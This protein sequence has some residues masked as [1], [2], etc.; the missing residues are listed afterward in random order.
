[1]VIGNELDDETESNER[2]DVSTQD[3]E[4][5]RGSGG[6]IKVKGQSGRSRRPDMILE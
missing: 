5:L 1:V 4:S 6:T 2:C 3:S